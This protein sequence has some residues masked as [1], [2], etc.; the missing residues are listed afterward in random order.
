MNRMDVHTHVYIHV[1]VC[2]QSLKCEV[3]NSTHYDCQFCACSCV[4]SGKVRD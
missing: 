4:H 1:C 3:P 2:E